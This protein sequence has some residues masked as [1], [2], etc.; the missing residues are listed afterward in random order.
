MIKLTRSAIPIEL[1]DALVEKLTNEFKRKGTSVWNKP[2]IKEKLL[3]FSYD[4]C[5]YCEC[6]IQEE[7]KYME[8]EHFKPKHLFPDLVLDWL[9]LLP[10]CKRCNGRKGGKTI[11]IIDPTVIDP[12]EHLSLKGFR[13]RPKTELGQA[14]IDVVDL[15]DRN[16]LVRKRA[17]IG[18]KISTDLEVI[19]IMLNEYSS[20]P[21]TERLSKAIYRRIRALLIV[22]QPYK[23]YCATAAT[24]LLKD[25]NC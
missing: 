9:N 10:S 17:E 7:S 13:L 15:N 5:C 14:T 12:R 25:S 18:Q 4:K 3:A 2:F 8:V 21:Q 6:Y 16:R 19:L 11:N 20:S 24:S 22:S 1:T 23:E